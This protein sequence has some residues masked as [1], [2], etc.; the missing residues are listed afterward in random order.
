MAIPPL[1]GNPYNGYINP[2]YWVDDHPLLYGN[3]GS[4][5]PS[6]YQ[7]MKTRRLSFA[8]ATWQSPNQRWYKWPLRST[9][10]PRPNIFLYL[11]NSKKKILTSRAGLSASVP[12]TVAEWLKRHVPV[13]IENEIIEPLNI[14]NPSKSKQ[15]K[16]LYHS[17]LICQGEIHGKSMSMETCLRLS[18]FF[19]AFHP[20]EHPI[21][22]RVPGRWVACLQ[23][24][25][26]F[27]LPDS[28][29]KRNLKH[30]VSLTLFEIIFFLLVLPSSSCKISNLHLSTANS[31]SLSC[32]N[33]N[34]KNHP[35]VG[36]H[37]GIVNGRNP[38][39]SEICE[40]PWNI[41]LKFQ[42]YI[43]STAANAGCLP[44]N[45]IIRGE[46]DVPL[47]T[48]PYGKSLYKPYISLYSGCLWVIIPKNPYISPISTM[49]TLL[50]VH[51]IVPWYHPYDIWYIYIS[52]YMS[53]LIS[54][55]L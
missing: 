24:W 21:S 35:F 54:L 6:T 48:Y 2:Y 20:W 44:I 16:S 10:L 18:S 36:S 50:G 49:G 38:A 37:C 7:I 30:Q 40:T 22:L 52:V 51:P 47:P 55:F 3:N 23:V 9:S 32:L 11:R 17:L 43:S 13:F 12:L 15:T 4:L 29:K 34:N 5:D 19:L 39:P 46:L 14:Q 26:H 31:S 28:W 1:I 8:Q 45:S 53:R 33:V 41:C 25:C 42:T 27:P